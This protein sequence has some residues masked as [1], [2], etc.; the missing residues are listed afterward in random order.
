MLPSCKGWTVAFTGADWIGWT[1]RE[2]ERVVDGG[3]VRVGSSVFIGCANRPGVL[4]ADSI[5]CVWTNEVFAGA[6]ADLGEDEA[7]GNEEVIADG[8][9]AEALEA[10]GGSAGWSELW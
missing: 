5:D 6:A 9:T 3:V 4:S 1:G 8:A 7:A 10:D 2:A